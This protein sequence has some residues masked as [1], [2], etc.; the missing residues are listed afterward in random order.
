ME[1]AQ[2]SNFR[3]WNILNTSVWPN[4][5]VKGSYAGEVDYLKDYYTKRFNWLDGKFNVADGAVFQ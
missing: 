5:V 1:D 2:K 3:K 4:V